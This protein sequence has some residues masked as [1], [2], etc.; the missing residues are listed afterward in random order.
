M[1][2]HLPTGDVKQKY[3]PKLYPQ[4]SILC[5]SCHFQQDSNSHW[6]LYPT[7]RSSIIEGLK[8]KWL[9]LIALIIEQKSTSSEFTL[10]D[11][12]RIVSR[13]DIFNQTFSRI[14]LNG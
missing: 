13:L 5:Q 9:S 8:A 2:H 12:A 14:Q 7:H 10:T 11:I 1:N 3:F 6:T 4:H